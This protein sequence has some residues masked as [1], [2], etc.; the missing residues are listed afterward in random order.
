MV[1]SVNRFVVFVV[2]VLGMS[3][4]ARTARAE[5][6]G[7]ASEAIVEVV[8]Y[9]HYSLGVAVEGGTRVL[10]PYET[11]EVDHAGAIDII[12]ANGPQK[13]TVVA[14]DKATGLALL[15][16][17]RTIP[18]SLAPSPLHLGSPGLFAIELSNEPR[19]ITWKT[20]PVPEVPHSQ[21]GEANANGTETK[22]TVM[23]PT[24][25]V[26][27]GSPIID[28]AGQL[29]GIVRTTS[30]A[31]ALRK[32]AV[33]VGPSLARMTAPAPENARR[34]IIPYGGGGMQ[35]E[36]SKNGGVW[37]GVN[38]HLAARWHDVIE[39][40]AD[41]SFTFLLPSAK[42]DECG[43]PPCFAGARAV[44]TPQIGPHFSLSTGDPIGITPTVG[45]ALGA[46]FAYRGEG[47]PVADVRAPNAWVMPVVGVSINFGL[48][49]LHTRVRIP[50]GDMDSP[51]VEVG[52]GIAF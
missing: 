7:W 15:A 10:V 43:E 49:E 35:M 21:A 27:A 41:A 32:G 28:E 23:V 42:H 34:T 29:V 45:V 38:M 25:S 13:A 39:A 51:G 47:A 44:L 1:R 11:I 12:D 33:I 22:V 26:A 50:Y 5:P 52:C 19:K 46:Q 20:Y 9:E 16:V 48:G 4:L 40:R 6:P 30:G 14:T 2:V 8:A 24:Y 3:S 37:W 17:E 18:A 31:L 36:F